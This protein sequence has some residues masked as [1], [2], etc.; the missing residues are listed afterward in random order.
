MTEQDEGGYLVPHEYAYG[1]WLSTT[2]P[3]KD[4]R[5]IFYY[6]SQLLRRIVL[7]FSQLD[8]IIRPHGMTIEKKYIKGILDTIKEQEEAP[9]RHDLPQEPYDD[10]LFGREYDHDLS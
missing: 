2:V 10:L 1:G 7:L 9:M 5:R 3:R 6:L 4:W 8:W